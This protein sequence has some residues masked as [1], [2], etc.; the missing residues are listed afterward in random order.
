MDYFEA[1]VKTLLE[2]DGFWTRQSFKVNISKEDKRNIGKP[3]IPRPEID[4]IA[5]KPAS[6]EILVVEVKS[7]LDS[8]GVHLSCLQERHEI[9]EGRYKLFT[10]ENYREIVFTQLNKDLMSLGLIDTKH[11]IRLGLAAGNVYRKSE[12]EINEYFD[13]QSMFFWGPSEI[14]KRIQGL[15]T[16]GY[17]N[18][19]TVIA[20]K[21][22]MRD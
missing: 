4:L 12:Q 15:A 16:K 20:A 1:I 9:P 19:P 3:T 8:S 21:V 7:Y 2:D 22:L 18:D 5:F 13:S 10:C 11:K 6:K 14:K 17:E